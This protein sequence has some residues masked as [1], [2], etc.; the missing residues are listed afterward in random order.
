VPP[1]A[2]LLILLVA[3]CSRGPDERGTMGET[4]RP[5]TQTA[6]ETSPGPA[7]ASPAFSREAFAPPPGDAGASEPPVP[8]TADP[9]A[10]DE[11]LAAAPRHDGGDPAGAGRGGLL[12]TDTGVR[13]DGGAE[14]AAPADP[15][16]GARI[17]VGKV[18]L[19]P[20]MSSPTIE[21]AARAQIYWPLVQRCRADD[22][23]ILPPEVIHLSF[24]LDRDGYV[25][26]ATILA[27]PREPRF[28]D[29]AR[30]MAREL[31][32][33]TFRAPAAARGLPQSVA[34]DVPSVD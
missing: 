9:A 32:M 33:S 11:I 20:G 10:L 3:A 24:H 22:G 29:A 31:G 5:P 26:P 14:G 16:K 4:P 19:E 12:G 2:A 6:R 23:A 13:G 1:R 15:S 18:T 21:R 17:R 8:A 7:P 28:A 30:C 25:V 34:M 27:V